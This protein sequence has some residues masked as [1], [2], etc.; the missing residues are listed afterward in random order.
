MK[1][2]VLSFIY[3]LQNERPP[4]KW[5]MLEFIKLEIKLKKGHYQRLLLKYS[6]N[7]RLRLAGFKVEPQFVLYNMYCDSNILLA[8]TIWIYALEMIFIAELFYFQHKIKDCATELVTGDKL[9]V[10]KLYRIHSST[11]APF[12]IFWTC[13]K[14]GIYENLIHT[15]SGFF[16][17][18]LFVVFI[19]ILFL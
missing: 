14:Q 15:M 10:I 13:W 11:M 18:E 2:C 19:Q 12:R 9:S 8:A 5:I 6:V 17:Q 16:S 4:K 7:A 1:I 3:L